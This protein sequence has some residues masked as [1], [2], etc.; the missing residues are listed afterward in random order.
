MLRRVRLCTVGN[1]LKICALA[2]ELLCWPVVKKGLLALL[3]VAVTLPIGHLAYDRYHVPEAPVGTEAWR[4]RADTLARARVFVPDAPARIVH[5][6]SGGPDIECRYDPETTSGTTPKFDCILAT[7][8]TVK[9][10]YGVNPEIAGEVAATSLL[11]ALGFGADHVSIV[12][13]VRCYGCP[14]S[15]YR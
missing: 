15:P 1:H 3:A 5:P 4:L 6:P 13:R 12:R 7:G 14:R 10:K 11:K 8:D 9:V 2:R